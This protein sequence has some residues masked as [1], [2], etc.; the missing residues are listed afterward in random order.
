MTFT[1]I[2]IQL[3]Y[4]FETVPIAQLPSTKAMHVLFENSLQWNGII[5]SI[6][7]VA[8]LQLIFQEHYFYMTFLAA[9][10]KHTRY[11]VYL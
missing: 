9:I 8:M 7:I 3:S 10:N 5:I 11:I 2:K 1:I 6:M 4:T